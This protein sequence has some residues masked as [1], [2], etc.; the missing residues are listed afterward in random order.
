MKLYKCHKE[1]YATPMNRLEYNDYRKW[2]SLHTSYILSISSK[3]L[4]GS[5]LTC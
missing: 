1:V 4:Q 3:I 5:T 2:A